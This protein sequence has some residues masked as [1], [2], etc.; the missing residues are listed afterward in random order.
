MGL[1][2]ERMLRVHD[3][4]EREFWEAVRLETPKV[5]DDLLKTLAR[6]IVD[7]TSKAQERGRKKGKKA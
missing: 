3:G 2:V 7:E 4:V 6:Y 5:I 1:P